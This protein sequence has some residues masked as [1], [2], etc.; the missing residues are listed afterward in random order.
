MLGVSAA[1]LFAGVLG[2]WVWLSF[3][4]NL[5]IE[6]PIDTASEIPYTVTSAGD[7]RYESQTEFYEVSLQYPN[8]TP[9]R[10][11]AGPAADAR[12]IQRM[13]SWLGAHIQGFISNGDF[14]NLTQ[15]DKDI[16][17]FSAGRKYALDI[18]YD[19]Y[20]SAK[21]ISYVYTVY[22]DTLGAHPNA[23]FYTVMFDKKTGKELTL[24]DIFEGEWLPY[25]AAESKRQITERLA[26]AYGGA[27]YVTLFEEGLAPQEGN[28]LNAYLDGEDVVI[29]FDPYQVAAYAAGAQMVRIPIATV[30]GFLKAQYH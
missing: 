20:T 24:G 10:Q 28:F 29:L 2:A 3:L 14:E 11:T 19:L 4:T 25:V 26:E 15:E 6:G 8:A 27:Q 21:T 12:A 1:V 18:S 7:R 5:S 23:Y 22:V 13:E 16:I 17:G 30:R 9:L